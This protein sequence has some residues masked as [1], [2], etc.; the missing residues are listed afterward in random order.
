MGY[1]P[2]DVAA[3]GRS[4][5]DA[6]DRVASASGL[7]RLPHQRRRRPRKRRNDCGTDPS[8]I[9]AGALVRPERRRP[10][11]VLDAQEPAR[12]ETQKE[13]KA[14]SGAG[15]GRG[16]NGYFCTNSAKDM[17]GTLP[18]N[19]LPASKEHHPLFAIAPRDGITGLPNESVRCKNDAA[20]CGA[21]SMWFTN[22][23]GQK[24]AI[25]SLS[26]IANNPP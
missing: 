1:R 12:S 26:Q 7:A 15:R 10:D 4:V 13:Q 22:C 16:P 9:G 18:P 23:I 17:P 6:G 3:L 14:A 2:R 25:A 20:T 24:E 19:T 21:L 11:P 5:A 8:D